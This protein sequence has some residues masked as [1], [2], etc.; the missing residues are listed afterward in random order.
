MD[1]SAI[2][3]AEKGRR[4]CLRC[5]RVTVAILRNRVKLR[6]GRGQGMAKL[7][8]TDHLKLWMFYQERA[9]KIKEA[10]FKTVTWTTGFAAALLGFIFVSFL[11]FDGEKRFWAMTIPAVTGV[12]ICVYSII[13]I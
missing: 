5:E 10:M 2:Q 12:V 11:N 8:D 13:A 3:K 6:A 9:D 7:Q 1:A 4:S